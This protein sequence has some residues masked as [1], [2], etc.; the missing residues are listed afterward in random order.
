[1]DNLYQE[2]LTIINAKAR[3]EKYK[4]LLTQFSFPGRKSVSSSGKK[5]FFLTGV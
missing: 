3:I 5:H 2:N 1:M 4:L